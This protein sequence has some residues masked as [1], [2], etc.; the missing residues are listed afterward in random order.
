MFL[1]SEW[2]KIFTPRP[3]SKYHDALPMLQKIMR[4][5]TQF[6]IILFA[7]VSLW[8]TSAQANCLVFAQ[9]ERLSNYCLLNEVSGKLMEPQPLPQTLTAKQLT[10]PPIFLRTALL[11]IPM[12]TSL[13]LMACQ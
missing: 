3:L 4:T 12:L 5:T 11:E 10:L 7:S 6:I 9:N 1:R 2:S 8:T 13:A